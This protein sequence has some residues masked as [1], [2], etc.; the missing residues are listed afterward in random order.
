MKLDRLGVRKKD[1]SGIN[2]KFLIFHRITSEV[3]G[4]YVNGIFFL[5]EEKESRNKKIDKNCI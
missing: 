3:A 1:K 5:N 4:K 2:N